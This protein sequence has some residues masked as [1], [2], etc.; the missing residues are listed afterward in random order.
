MKP[1]REQVIVVTGATS[2]NGLAI[3]E[4]AVAR[5]AAV[6][7]AARNTDALEAIRAD[8]A[9]R[10]R[11]VAVCTADIA[12]DADVR[13]IAD[14]AISSFGGFDSWINNAAAATY[15]TLEQVP[16]AD[17]R[18]VFDVN[19]FGVLAGSLVAANH[20]RSR[21]GAIINIGS[22]LSERAILEQG[23]Y[24]ATKHAVQALTDTLR[25]ELERDGAPISVTLI[26]PSAID[27]LFPE[28][29]R[30]FMEAPPRLPPPLYT[31][32]VVADA[33]LF[34]C[35]TPRRELYVGGGGWLAAKLAGLAPRLTDFMMEAG[36][37]AVQQKPGDAGD[38]A[39]RDNLYEPRAD[40]ARR[41]SQHVYARN[42]SLLVQAQKLP[43]GL[44][45]AALVGL[46]ALVM[47]GRA[48]RP[49]PRG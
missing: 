5:G 9:A 31:P 16:V 47:A 18:H 12:V 29:A 38:P 37:V 39:R 11:R 33:V 46:G 10:G 26:K 15:G 48:V 35:T 1:L 23:P 42:S 32:G 6:V 49:R 4:E 28:H 27:T 7:M 44:A 25:M 19:Y 40:G 45:T 17:H 13:R 34:A 14:V 3:A 22:I 30:N 41:G 21:G 24:C 20:L 8:L 43:G 36:G 2:G